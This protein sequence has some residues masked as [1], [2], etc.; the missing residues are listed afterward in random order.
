MRISYIIF[1]AFKN[2][3]G[4][5]L[6][7]ILT[8]GG[9]AISVGFVVFLISLGFGL[10]RVSTKQ[11]ANLEALQILDVTITKSKLVALND[12]TLEKFKNL[13][14]VV[15][16]Q[17]QV[18][19]ATK[20]SFNTSEIDGVVY[21]KDLG[22]L[23]LEDIKLA[24][25]KKYT[26]NVDNEAIINLAAKE[27]LAAGD[28]VGK[29]ISLDVIVRSEL[30]PKDVKSKQFS[31]KLTVV[32]VIDDKSAPF[33][34]VPMHVFADE[35]VTNYT[36]AK[37]KVDNKDVVDKTKLQVESL[38]FKAS[39]VKETVDQINQFFSVFQII[40]ISFG[41]IAII[42][43]CLGMFNTLTISLL[44]KT[45]EVG[46]M[47]ALGT[48]RRDIYRLFTFESILIGSLGSISG[49]VIGYSLGQIL[50]Y[51]ILGLAKATGNQA[52]EI[53]YVPFYM[54]ALILGAA[55][56]ISLLTGLYPAR[57]AARISP[58]DALRY[59]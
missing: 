7:T 27:Q 35:G 23:K 2:L 42:V 55:L 18:S 21:G 16:V 9:V 57:R 1:L 53:F 52:V 37:I 12:D 50:N 36:G 28:I 54:I 31:K 24:S 26:E 22:F 49:V 11:I 10:Q 25:G 8:A 45:R 56:I 15:D 38:G 44:E 51:S 34:Y 47:K 29:E 58:L 5:K 13:G 48:T 14:N 4:H 30:L 6:R 20:I 41:A 40:L 19:S 17:P 39:S 43:A 33:V 46:F 32:G 59:E 3:F